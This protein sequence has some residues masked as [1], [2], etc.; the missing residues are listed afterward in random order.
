MRFV[1]KGPG[2]KG[3]TYLVCNRAIRGLDCEKTGWRYDDLEASF[4]TYVQEIDLASLVHSETDTA[5]RKGLANE[6]AALNGQLTTIGEENERAYELYI[7]GG[8]K[9]DFVAKKLEEID[10]TAL[11]LKGVIQQKE[12][13]L[14]ALTADLAKFYES[15]DQIK[16]LVE[17]MQNRDG[18]DAYK[19]RSLLA[20]RL[21]S[22]VQSMSVASVGR[23]RF[24]P[25][26]GDDSME[27]R[28]Y[29]LITFKDGSARAVYPHP[30]DPQQFAEQIT[31]ADN[32]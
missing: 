13:E 23:S 18:Q 7:K 4:L 12:A 17:Q 5:K 25:T 16:A 22:I 26:P 31:S 2:P 30:D 20:S 29:F 24:G 28:R 8:S 3:G 10:Q 32:D 15:K 11:Q 1:N 6:I 14:V 19:M 21:K 27:H 9:S